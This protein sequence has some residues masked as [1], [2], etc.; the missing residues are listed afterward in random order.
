MVHPI[1]TAPEAALETAVLLADEDDVVAFERAL[2]GLVRHARLDRDTLSKALGP[3]LRKEPVETS[4]WTQLDLYDVAAAVRGDE[5]RAWHIRTRR[6][7]PEFRH[8]RTGRPATPPEAM[9]TARLVEALKLI[10]TGDQPYLLALSTHANG[11]V[12]AATLAAR[13]AEFESLRVRPAPV[14]LA[15]A[16]LRVTPTD[17]QRVLDAAG[18]LRSSAGRRLARWLGEGGAP[19]GDTTPEG[20]PTGDPT[21][22]EPGWWD[23]AEPR[24]DHD[25][26]LPGVAAALLGPYRTHRFRA[27]WLPQLP[28]HRDELAAHFTHSNERYLLPRLMEARG[29]AGYATHWQIL[30]G[31]DR[32]QDAAVDALLVLAAQG[33]LDAGLF[34]GQWQALLRHGASTR[35]TAALRA[36]AETGAHATVWSILEAALPALLRDR[37]VRGAGAV[38][39]LAVDCAS[40]SGARG[41][42]PEVDEVAA[43]KGSSQTVR[44]ARLLRDVLS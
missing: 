30:C 28:H 15:Q 18:A 27:Y 29:P 24:T 1:A 26:P 17:D 13:I 34:A 31:L 43:R 19:H 9:L 16:L 5:P 12:D 21:G 42:I 39:A 25:L 38:L 44:N 37:P 41:R 11:A 6:E 2:D 36:A 23:P 40:R 32:N 10:G 20:W 33:Q 35:A 8:W 14:D 7:N 3:V 22:A 4:D